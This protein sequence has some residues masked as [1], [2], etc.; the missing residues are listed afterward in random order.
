MSTSRSSGGGGS[1]P[2]S[3]PSM[4]NDVAARFGGLRVSLPSGSGPVSMPEPKIWTPP[5]ATDDENPLPDLPSM[6]SFPSL[7]GSL[8]DLAPRPHPRLRPPH[9]AD[10]PNPY[11]RLT[12]PQSAPPPPLCPPSPELLSNPWGERPPM[13]PHARSHPPPSRRPGFSPSMTPSNPSL[14]VSPPSD[15]PLFSKHEPSNKPTA[16]KPSRHSGPPAPQLPDNYLTP[17]SPTR[18][19]ASSEPPSTQCNGLTKAGNRCTRLVKSPHPYILATR[20]ADDE[21]EVVI[22]YRDCV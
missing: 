3:F 5:T 15:G 7:P 1:A 14:K 11:D 2:W 20:A 19:R 22:C 12:T 18:P 21:I 4:L 13:S 16:S 6:P 8:P 10:R 17:P 9:I